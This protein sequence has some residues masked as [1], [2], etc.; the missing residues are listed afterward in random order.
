MVNFVTVFVAEEAPQFD[1]DKVTPGVIGFAAIAVLAVAVIFL[2]IDM[3]RRVRRIQF[4]EQVRE[5]LAQEIAERDG[6]LADPDPAVAEAAS[7][8]AAE[9]AADESPTGRDQ[10]DE[11]TDGSGR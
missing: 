10:P 3:N 6:Q 11:T 5:E 7:E 1:P 4:R 9:A 2:V 8:A